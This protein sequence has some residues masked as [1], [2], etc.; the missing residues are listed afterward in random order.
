LSCKERIINTDVFN[1]QGVITRDG[2][3][4]DNPLEALINDG[5]VNGRGNIRTPSN[6]SLQRVDVLTIDKAAVKK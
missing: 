1:Q 3:V 5:G 4:F 2:E 6:W